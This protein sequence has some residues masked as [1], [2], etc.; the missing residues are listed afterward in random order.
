MRMQTSE[1]DKIMEYT[2][3]IIL[4][5][6]GVS[7]SYQSGIDRLMVLQDVDLAIC[8]G[9]FISILGKSGSGKTTLLHLMA[10]ITV[11]DAGSIRFQGHS[12]GISDCELRRYRRKHVG[13]V[14]QDYGLLDE[15]TVYQNIQIAMKM[16]DYSLDMD[17]ILKKLGISEKKNCYPWQLSGGEKQ[18]VAIARALVKNSAL[19]LCDE[20]T[21]ALDRVSGR[22]VI[23][24]LCDLSKEGHT[25]ILITHDEDASRAASKRYYLQDGRLKSWN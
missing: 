2:S 3:N 21:G 11:P 20:P 19:I 4:E 22:N 13:L 23:N 9:E 12:I 25:I 14:L 16:T 18:R 15:L 17:T 8:K 24:L 6:T 5:L 1:K 10:G 7:K